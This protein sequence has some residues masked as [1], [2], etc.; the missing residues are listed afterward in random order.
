MI[1]KE[2]VVTEVNAMWDQAAAMF[3]DNAKIGLRTLLDCK[4]AFPFGTPNLWK[5]EW[6]PK[7]QAIFVLTH[8]TVYLNPADD[9]RPWTGLPITVVFPVPA[10]S[11]NGEDSFNR[12]AWQVMDAYRKEDIKSG[13]FSYKEF[14]EDYHKQYATVRIS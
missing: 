2:N 3:I 1:D 6:L 12:W 13:V 4:L 10:P 7:G 8:N 14:M 11:T 5:S 9:Q